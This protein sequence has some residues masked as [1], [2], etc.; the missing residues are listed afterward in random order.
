[1]ATTIH[2]PAADAP[3]NKSRQI[4]R[5]RRKPFED[6][7]ATSAMTAHTRMSGNGRIVIPAAMREKLGLQKDESVVME[8]V[9]GVLR[10][11]SYLSRIRRIQAEFAHL[12]PAGILASEQ[13]IL[14][15]RQEA[16]LENESPQRARELRR[17]RDGHED[18]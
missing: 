4:A 9:D 16:L 15:R 13:L 5:R 11:E 18:A 2:I 6:S 17:M 10:I 7:S 14:E 12:A 8:V 3:A 1:M